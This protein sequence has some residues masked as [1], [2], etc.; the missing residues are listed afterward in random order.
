MEIL[1]PEPFPEAELTALPVGSGSLIVLHGLLPHLSQPN[2]SANPRHAYSLHV[3]DG[4]TDYPSDNW[5]QP[6]TQE[7]HS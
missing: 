7:R 1:D 2:R 5:L 4:G 6:L 3:V